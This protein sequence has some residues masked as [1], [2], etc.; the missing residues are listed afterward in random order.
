V[1]W[2][3]QEYQRACHY[4]SNL[5][6]EHETTMENEKYL[7]HNLLDLPH[8]NRGDVHYH[9]GE[10]LRV[11]PSIGD[12]SSDAR[13]SG[14]RANGDKPSYEQVPLFA[15]EGAARVLKFGASKYRR[16]NWAKGMS[17][18]VVFDCLL[19]HMVAW[20]RGEELDPESGLPHLDHAMCN[21]LFLSA[22][23]D[24]YPEGDDRIAEFREGG[25]DAKT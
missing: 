8:V 18:S 16:G 14:A 19:R 9:A 10:P 3:E 20:Q 15:L 21:L 6:R 5:Y 13:G 2:L 22:Y 4:Y 1:K 7:A 11:G 25:V 24:L 17:W 23:R 12:I